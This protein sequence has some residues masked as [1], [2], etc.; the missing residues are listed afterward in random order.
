MVQLSNAKGLYWHGQLKDFIGMDKMHGFLLL[1]GFFFG[2]ISMVWH[3]KEAILSK[4][5][6][7]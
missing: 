5:L 6:T 2:S 1:F 7:I 4:S 3:V